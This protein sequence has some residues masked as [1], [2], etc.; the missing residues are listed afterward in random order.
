MT[1]ENKD[2][3]HALRSNGYRVTMSRLLVLDAVCACA[4]HAT[5]SSIQAWLQEMV[6]DIDR[7]TVYR[8]LDVLTQVGLIVESEMDGNKIYNIAGES[9]HHHLV[10]V[11]CDQVLT[12]PDDVLQ[13]VIQQI[14]STYGYEIFADHLVLQGRCTRCKE[15]STVSQP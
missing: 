12:I 11:S 3:I 4:E 1:H 8:S 2:Y 6:P 13:P 14:Q 10:C 7:S 9:K 5:I 15:Q